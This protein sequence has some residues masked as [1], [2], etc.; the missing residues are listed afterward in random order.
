VAF[1]A[2]RKKR[3]LV[4]NLDRPSCWDWSVT[5]SDFLSASRARTARDAYEVLVRWQGALCAICGEIAMEPC[6][7]HDHANGFIRGIL[8]G[9][10]NNREG[11]GGAGNARA[12]MLYRKISAADILDMKVLYVKSWSRGN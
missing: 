9:S 10:C 1:S 3:R 4:T 2:S 11:K 6:L 5:E 12:F 8:C 7:D